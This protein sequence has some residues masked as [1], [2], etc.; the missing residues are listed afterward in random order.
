M[1]DAVAEEKAKD[2]IPPFTRD[3][4]GA[5]DGSLLLLFLLLLVCLAYALLN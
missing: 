4:A 2:F 5:I 3:A 1:A